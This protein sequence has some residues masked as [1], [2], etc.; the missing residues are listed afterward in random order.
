M[1]LRYLVTS[2]GVV[3]LAGVGTSYKRATISVEDNNIRYAFDGS[4]PAVDLGHILYAAG[5]LVISNGV[6]IRRF[7]MIAVAGDATVMVTLI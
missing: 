6:D 2:S 5:T 4:T 7:R 3:D 1:L